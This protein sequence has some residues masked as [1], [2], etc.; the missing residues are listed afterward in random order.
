MAAPLST[1][2]PKSP[3]PEVLSNSPYMQSLL[4]IETRAKLAIMGWNA[5]GV[6][7][8]LPAKR[9]ALDSLSE[10]DDEDSD[11]DQDS[12]DVAP[13]DPAQQR[14]PRLPMYHPGFK[15]AEGDVQ[16]LLRVF[17]D[18]LK[19]ANSLGVA[20]E[21]ANYLWNQIIKNRNILYQDEI[22]IAVTGDTGTGKS[23]TTNALLGEDL[24]PEGD[25]GAACTNVVTEFRQKTLSTNIG[26]VQAEVQFYC[27][28]YCTDDLVTNWFKVWFNTRQKL[29]QDE[30]SVDDEDRARKDAA[31][32][33]LEHLFASRVAPESL[34][35]FMSSGK[36]LK[37]NPALKKLLKWTMDIHGQFVPDGEL[38]VPFKSSTHNDMREQLRPFRMRAPNARYQGKVLPFS[39][40]PFVEIIRPLLQDGICLADVPGTKDVNMYRVTAATAYLQ[41]C[42]MTIVVVDIKR[43]TSDQSFRQHYLDAHSRRHHGSVIL[44]A[45][46][47]DELN[48]DGG[49][50]L[51]LDIIAE[52]QLVPIEDELADLENKLQAI[53]NELESNK[54][55]MKR[56]RQKIQQNTA[57]ED[58]LRQLESLKAANKALASRKKGKDMMPRI[59]I[60]EKERKDAR[61]ACRNRFVA[62][63]MNRMYSQNT[64]DD[65]GAAAFCVSNRMYMRHRR[66]YNTKNLEKMPT[67]KLDE[68]QIPAACTYIAGIPSQGRTA[69]LEHFI[70]FEVPMLL[71]IVQMS[72][73]KTTEAR[74]EHV[75]KIIDKSIK[76]LESRVRAVATK[77]NK[78]FVKEL[79]A[80]L[81]NH[82]LQDRFDKVAEKKLDELLKINAASHKALVNKRGTYHQKKLGIKHDVNAALLAPTKQAVLDAFRD[83]LDAA[84]ASFKAQ[85]AQTIKAGINDLNKQLKDDPQ[86]LAGD[87]YQV[88]FGNNLVGYEKDITLK[89]DNSMK[90]LR[91][92]LIAIYQK[93]VKPG[94]KC[95][96]SLAMEPIYEKALE[97]KPGK[98]QKLRDV[99]H[100]Y[101]EEKI[102]GLNGPFPAI[103]DEVEKDVKALIKNTCD[104][105]RKEVVEILKT[106]RAAF[107]RQK[108]RKE[109]DTP[110]G[111]QFRQELHELVAE[112]RRILEG[113]VSK[114]LEKCKE[115]K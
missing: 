37:D 60:L 107:Q 56:L 55:E 115:H 85:T 92:G 89:V 17:M 48:D 110:E 7:S 43:A 106:I 104:K 4:D 11:D 73:S 19:A 101:L 74:I 58:G 21:E 88:C 30:D 57:T 100:A 8:M 102:I 52:E 46:R 80:A 54:L 97:Q 62:A 66:G 20:R 18:F 86:A 3:T 77:C 64:G 94:D 103:A 10:S 34:E 65:A 70:H 14:R 36:T 40:W 82:E 33:C 83:L 72:C 26:A 9:K 108:N 51:Q 25:S 22:R 49:S 81:S 95:Y 6:E 112:A 1:N 93:A 113:V 96:L 114:S 50:T 42:E 38:S 76:N 16:E 90:D 27:L 13:Y 28:E 47:A 59:P 109:H 61:I 63:G 105:L 75:T 5:G 99:R 31:L 91:T 23:A 87:A 32:E 24:T 111:R 78:T 29:M 69:V 2:N 71:S 41:Q 68:T 35:D 39:P 53:D 45:T 15:Q 12:E 79:V 84:P 44:V 67:M 98:G